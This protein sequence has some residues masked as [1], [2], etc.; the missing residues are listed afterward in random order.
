MKS[1]HGGVYF[2]KVIGNDDTAKTEN[3]IKLA[4]MLQYY[5]FLNEAQ[6]RN[7][8]LALDTAIHYKGTNGDSTLPYGAS[9][10][11]VRDFMSANSALSIGDINSES[12]RY[13]VMPS[14]AT[15]YMLGKIIFENLYNLVSTKLNTNLVTDKVAVKKLFDLFLRNGEIPLKVLEEQVKLEY[16]ITI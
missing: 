13:A 14:Q 8:R 10:K 9:I 1:L 2:S 16:G 15:G 7:M 5:G 11:Q 12:I 6:L 4:N 3:S